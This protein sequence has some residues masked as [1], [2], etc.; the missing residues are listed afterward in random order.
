METQYRAQDHE[1]VPSTSPVKGGAKIA[2]FM[3]K[4]LED[5]TRPIAP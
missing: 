1:A 3:E 2:R 4:V 5:H